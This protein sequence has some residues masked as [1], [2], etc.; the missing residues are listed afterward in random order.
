MVKSTLGT[1]KVPVYQSNTCVTSE[2]SFNQWFRS[3]PGV[4]K[5][6]SV[7]LLATYHPTDGTYTY[8]SDTFFPIDNQLYGNEK[9]TH[10]YGF[11]FQFHVQFTYKKG[12][13]GIS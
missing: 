2:S 3:V 8:S 12:R 5:I 11:T 7:A 13:L 1:D 10:N 9:Y 6:G 4:N